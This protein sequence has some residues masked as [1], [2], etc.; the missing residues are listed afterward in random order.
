M[1]GN[2]DSCKS[3]LL[4]IC[5][6]ERHLP[7]AVHECRGHQRPTAIPC[8]KDKKHTCFGLPR[9]G[10]SSLHGPHFNRGHVCIGEGGWGG[11]M[12][13]GSPS[14][15]NTLLPLRQNILENIFC[16]TYF[17]NL[18]TDSSVFKCLFHAEGFKVMLLLALPSTQ[19]R[20]RSLTNWSIHKECS[21]YRERQL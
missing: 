17:L 5:W 11:C 21:L 20:K 19:C 10:R 13:K 2:A 1:F 14:H 6:W 3:E 9:T 7:G 4:T 12:T 18:R 8:Q 16:S 15:T